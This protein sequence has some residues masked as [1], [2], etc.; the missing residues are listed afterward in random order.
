MSG[1]QEKGQGGPGLING[2]VFLL[3]TSLE[4]ELEGCFSFENDFLLP[5]VARMS[6]AAVISDGFFI[7]IGIPEDFAAA[8]TLLD[9]KS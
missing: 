4:P 1:F 8:Q 3:A 9:G 7:D 5:G 6:V 2:G